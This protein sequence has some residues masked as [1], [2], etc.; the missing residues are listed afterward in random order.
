[1]KAAMVI[2]WLAV[3]VLA[4]LNMVYSPGPEPD[5]VYEMTNKHIEWTYAGHSRGR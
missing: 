1:M 2:T 4:V 3:V 5:V